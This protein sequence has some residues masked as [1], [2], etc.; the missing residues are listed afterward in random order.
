MEADEV[1]T[2]VRLQNFV[3]LLLLGL[4]GVLVESREELFA[5]DEVRVALL[6]VDLDVSKVGVNAEGKVGGKSPG[7]R[8]PREKGSRG[9][10]DELEGDGDCRSDESTISRHAP[11]FNE[12]E[13]KSRTSRVLDILVSLTSLEVGERGRATGRVGHD[14]QTSVHQVL[15]PQLAEYP[16]YRL[17]EARVERL[18]VVVEINP[19]SQSLDGPSPLGRVAHDDRAAL[20]VVLVDTHLHDVGLGRDAELFVNLVLDGESVGVPSEPSLDVEPVRV[21]EAGD[22][23]L[24]RRERRS[25]LR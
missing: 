20:G 1:F 19:S 4:G 7:S 2:L 9:I 11:D 3:L 15:L 13:M 14:L 6:V 21:S 16:P 22:D 23:V 17:H 10:R 5:E 8:G 24:R 25:A 18:V 12:I